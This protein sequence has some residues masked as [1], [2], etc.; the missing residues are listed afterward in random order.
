MIKKT[1]S[2]ENGKDLSTV[3]KGDLIT[4]HEVDTYDYREFKLIL[5]VMRNNKKSVSVKCVDG[6]MKNS[7]WKILK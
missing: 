6:Y 7:E 4:V 1:Y 3:K 2:F 5:E